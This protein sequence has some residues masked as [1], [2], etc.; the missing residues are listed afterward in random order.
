MTK[1][2]GN[3][4]VMGKS[5]REVAINRLTLPR[6]PRTRVGNDDKRLEQA[7]DRFTFTVSGERLHGGANYNKPGQDIDL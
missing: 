1:V 5:R 3:D 7:R 2:T 4:K 6:L